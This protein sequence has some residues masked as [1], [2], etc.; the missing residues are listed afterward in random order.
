MPVVTYTRPEVARVGLTEQE[1]A[2]LV[3]G[4]RVAEVP[5]TELDRALTADRTEGFIKLIAGPRALTRDLAGGR[6][7]G[8]TIVAD[9][10]GEMIAVPALAMATGMFPARL[11]LTVQAYPTWTLGVRQAAAQLFGAGARPAR[12]AE[13]DG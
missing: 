10:A 8:A 1:A 13:R 5:L 7:L 3:S 9:R 6:L 12:P 11:A 2:M 4:A